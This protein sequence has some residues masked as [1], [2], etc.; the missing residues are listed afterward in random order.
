MFPAR[1][2]QNENPEREDL[3]R[4]W[5]FCLLLHPRHFVHFHIHRPNSEP[6]TTQN[7]MLLVLALV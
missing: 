2:R 3:L 7:A 5:N 1:L 4:G 6:M